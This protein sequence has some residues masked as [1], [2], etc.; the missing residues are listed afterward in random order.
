MR[1]INIIEIHFDNVTRTQSQARQQ[2][3]RGAV[4]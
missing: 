2:Q 1:P 3:N 4:S